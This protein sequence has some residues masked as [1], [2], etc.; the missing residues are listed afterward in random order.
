MISSQL[1]YYLAYQQ[2]LIRLITPA[3]LKHC[4]SLVTTI[5]QFSPYGPFLSQL[6]WIAECCSGPWLSFFLSTLTRLV[7]S[8]LIRVLNAND[9][10]LY[11]TEL[12]PHLRCLKRHLKFNVPKTELLVYFKSIAPTIL[13]NSIKGTP[14]FSCSGQKRSQQWHNSFSPIPYVIL[15]QHPTSIPSLP[16]VMASGTTPLNW[17]TAAALN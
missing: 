14:F 12:I 3:S 16:L 13:P 8:N 15:Q 11:L 10:D 4:V 2:H 6:C 5:S 17:V 7:T 9:F 1:P